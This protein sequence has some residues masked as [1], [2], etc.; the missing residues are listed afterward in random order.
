MLGWK[1]AAALMLDRGFSAMG[2]QFERQ[3]R[4]IEDVGP[5]RSVGFCMRRRESGEG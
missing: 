1:S 2:M 4:W 3:V 5:S